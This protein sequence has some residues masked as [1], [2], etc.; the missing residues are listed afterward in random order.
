MVKKK[1]MID[2]LQNTGK[3]KWWSYTKEYPLTREEIVDK[4]WEYAQQEHMKLKKKDLTP[5]LIQALWDVKF[6]E[7]KP[8]PDETTVY[9]IMDVYDR[10]EWVQLYH[11]SFY[12]SNPGYNSKE[13]KQAEK[14]FNSISPDDCHKFGIYALYLTKEE[15]EGVRSVLNANLEQQTTDLLRGLNEQNKIRYVCD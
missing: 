5:G 10:W 14:L 6:V 15:V 3:Y 12:L 2:D 9:L 7:T 11:P 13:Y 8:N 4:F 1:Y